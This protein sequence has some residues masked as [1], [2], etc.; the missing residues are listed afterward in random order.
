M[1]HLALSRA[2]AG[3]SD[4]KRSCWTSCARGEWRRDHGRRT[5][6]TGSRPH[7]R[8]E[9]TRDSEYFDALLLGGDGAAKDFTPYLTQGGNRI[10]V[11][12]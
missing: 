10:A 4:S 12:V 7:F 1:F 3:P 2:L 6:L 5:S 9:S 11:P 8:S